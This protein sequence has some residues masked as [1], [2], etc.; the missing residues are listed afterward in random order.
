M[1]HND[2]QSPV[3]MALAVTSAYQR[4]DATPAGRVVSAGNEPYTDPRECEENDE[5]QSYE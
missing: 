2:H 3:A 1:A 4:T 5:S